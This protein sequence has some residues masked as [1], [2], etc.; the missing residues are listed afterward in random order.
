MKECE[1]QEKRERSERAVAVGLD[2]T[3]RGGCGER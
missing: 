2:E 1:I 3:G